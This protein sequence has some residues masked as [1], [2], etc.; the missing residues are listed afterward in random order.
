MA[1]LVIK[2]SLMIFLNRI[3]DHKRAFRLSLRII[4]AYIFL[5]WLT[6]LWMSVFQYWPISSNWGTTSE[7]MG[8]CIPD[9]MVRHTC[10]GTHVA[11]LIKADLACLGSTS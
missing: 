5:W 4:G 7:E 11:W 3:F 9:Y 6:M 2:A 8:D 10:P 1:M